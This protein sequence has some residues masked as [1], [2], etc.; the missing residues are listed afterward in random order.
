MTW[1]RKLLGLKAIKDTKREI[2]FPGVV[3]GLNGYNTLD[4]IF[5]SGFYK[6][7]LQIIQCH[8][9]LRIRNLASV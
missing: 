7:M 8:Q 5:I 9:V 4:P 3:S 1:F 2:L 6:I